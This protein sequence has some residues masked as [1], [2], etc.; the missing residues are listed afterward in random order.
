MVVGQ[1]DHLIRKH[2][3]ASVFVVREVQL[4]TREWTKWNKDVFNLGHVPESERERFE[5][6]AQIVNIAVE[7]DQRRGA[8]A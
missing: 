2:K 5:S 6:L 1:V 3:V 7:A 4:D 8:G